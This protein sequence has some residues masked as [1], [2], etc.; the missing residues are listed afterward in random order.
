VP[1]MAESGADRMGRTF[2][3]SVHLP[4]TVCTLYLEI[5]EDVM[6]RF[7][8]LFVTLCIVTVPLAQAFAGPT[9]APP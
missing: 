9:G 3:R 1:V 2:I 4:F 8:L 5:L 6:A 7:W